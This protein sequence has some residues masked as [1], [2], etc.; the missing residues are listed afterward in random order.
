MMN[1][2]KVN[3]PL[4]IIALFAALAEIAGTGVLLG[5]DNDLQ[6]IFIWFVMFFPFALVATFFV[7]LNFNPTVLYAPSDFTKEENFVKIILGNLKIESQV[8][9]IKELIA[10][11]K[12]EVLNNPEVAAD[13]LKVSMNKTLES[14]ENKLNEVELNSKAFMLKMFNFN[15]YEDLPERKRI[16]IELIKG[17]P[18]GVDYNFLIERSGLTKSRL[19]N[20]LRSLIAEGYVE[21]KNGLY[22]FKSKYNFH[23][24]FAG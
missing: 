1:A 2:K 18:A 9:E 20:E 19:S 11:S 16:I 23:S 3:N 7:T 22:F 15:N 8:S 24:Y 12:Q 17:N 14:A 13:E 6:R 5:L 4:T 10:E 21:H